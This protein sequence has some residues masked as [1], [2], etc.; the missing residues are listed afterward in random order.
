MTAPPQGMY[1]HVHDVWSSLEKLVV[2][3]CELQL[4][5]V[6]VDFTLSTSLIMIVMIKLLFA[7]VNYETSKYADEF[8]LLHRASLEDYFS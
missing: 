5:A 6:T 1:V 4:S 2:L 7:I 8:R 3:S